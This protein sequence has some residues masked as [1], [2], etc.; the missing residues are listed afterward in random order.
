MNGHHGEEVQEAHADACWSLFP[1]Y[2]PLLGSEME[3]STR[4]AVFTWYDL[5]LT[6]MD[7]S[8]HK[9]KEDSSQLP[10]LKVMLPIASLVEGQHRLNV[11][12]I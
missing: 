9:G 11:P 7:A 8:H 1:G 5:L 10:L 2:A 4:N 12:T 3:A 6:I